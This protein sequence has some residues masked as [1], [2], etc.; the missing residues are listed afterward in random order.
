MMS[1]GKR[2]RAWLM[3]VAS[4]LGIAACSSGSNNNTGATQVQALPSLAFSPAGVSIAL[5][6]SVTWVFGSVGHNVTFDAID[7][8]PADIPGTNANTS[9]SRVFGTAGRFDYHCTIHP[10]MTG[11]VI[12]SGQ[13]P[14]GYLIGP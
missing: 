10:T 3:A 4:A 8:H 7:G 2:M 11:Y 1:R 6:S 5:G 12:V 13:A 14:P 9:V